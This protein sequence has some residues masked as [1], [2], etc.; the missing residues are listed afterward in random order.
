M[1]ERPVPLTVG[2]L[3]NHFGKVVRELLT[4]RQTQRASR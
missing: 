1:A 2:Q 3:S 4:R